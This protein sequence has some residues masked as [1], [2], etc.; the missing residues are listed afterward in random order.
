MR[1]LLARTSS[2]RAG[3]TG[4]GSPGR[5]SYDEPADEHAENHPEQLDAEQ[6]QR[7]P[8][9]REVASDAWREQ[10]Q[11]HHQPHRHPRR[12]PPRLHP[13]PP[14]GGCS[15]AAQDDGGRTRGGLR[16]T[17]AEGQ[18]R[19]GQP[20]R[21]APATLASAERAAA[22][23]QAEATVTGPASPLLMVAELWKGVEVRRGR[24]GAV[25]SL[26]EELMAQPVG[27]RRGRACERGFAV[28]TRDRFGC[29]KIS[30]PSRCARRGFDPS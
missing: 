3:A 17:G 18:S 9:P 21:A 27:G 2:V 8:E 11:H 25:R 28:E 15:N 13:T 30:P 22:S 1:T 4:R 20:G 7:G 10:L 14:I 23:E 29:G 6:R 16:S 5:A 24:E 26:E 19:E 12:Q